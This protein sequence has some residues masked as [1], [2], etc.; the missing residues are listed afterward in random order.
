MSEKTTNV[1]FSLSDVKEAYEEY[2]PGTSANI[3]QIILETEIQELATEAI[4]FGV[5]Y[6][7]EGALAAVA[8]GTVSVAYTALGLFNTYMKAKEAEKYAKMLKSLA[9]A[10]FGGYVKAKISIQYEDRYIP[11]EGTERKIYSVSV[12]DWN[13]YSDGSVIV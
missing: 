9:V 12:L 6:L 3:Q 10:G 8:V 1:I 13:C 5:L 2:N 7:A 11:Y 4:K